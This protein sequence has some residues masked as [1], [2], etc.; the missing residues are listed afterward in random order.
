MQLLELRMKKQE[1]TFTNMSE[2]LR[3]VIV[4]SN[5]QSEIPKIGLQLTFAISQKCSINVDERNTHTNVHKIS[6]LIR[7]SSFEYILS[8]AT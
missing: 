7:S 6:L 3:A 5:E 4:F 1:A 8:S 2:H